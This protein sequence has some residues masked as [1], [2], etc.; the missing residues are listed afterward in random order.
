MMVARAIHPLGI[1]KIPDT[2]NQSFVC[3]ICEREQSEYAF[4][5]HGNRM[6]RCA[7]C[8]TLSPEVRTALAFSALEEITTATVNHDPEGISALIL[9]TVLERGASG[10]YLV[11]ASANDAAAEVLVAALPGD[12][13]RIEP[14]SFAAEKSDLVA[15]TVL[16]MVPLSLFEQPIAIRN[17]LYASL[18]PE[19]H[20]LLLQPMIDSRQARILGAGWLEWQRPHRFYCSRSHLHIALLKSG[21]DRVWFRKLRHPYTLSYIRDRL[22]GHRLIRPLRLALLAT[23]W[24]A[25]VFGNLRFRLPSGH[26]VVSCQKGQTKAEPKLSII[27]PVYNEQKTFVEVMEQ[28]VA[29]QIPGLAKEIII[30]ESNSDDGTREL[31]RRYESYPDVSV[32]WQPKPRGKGLAVRDGLAAATGDYVLIQDADLEYDFNDYEGLLAPLRADR[33]MFVLGSRHRGSW[34]MRVFNDAPV[35][36]SAFNFGHLFFTWLVNFL[37]GQRMTD[38]FTMFK[39]LRRDALF[40]ID[41]TCLRFDFDHELV[42]KL[43]RK[44]YQP[45]ELPVNYTARSFAEGKKVSFVKDGLTWVTTDLRLRFERLGK[46]SD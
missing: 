7:N 43:V 24:M 44:G 39:V 6:C 1:S 26:V 10:P 46:L 20:L 42:I 30:V 18:L 35:V 19:G 14:E 22:E 36:A 5:V 23:R 13:R 45:I 3:S 28:L 12:A 2:P 41:W 25:P 8:H 21:F 17:R 38:P 15:G 33:V 34:K 27:M 31:V 32:V 9:S 11:I 37:T 4:T 40:G 16:L 29:K